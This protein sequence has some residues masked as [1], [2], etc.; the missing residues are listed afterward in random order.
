MYNLR[1]AEMNNLPD[2]HITTQTIYHLLIIR[3]RLTSSIHHGLKLWNS[4]MVNC[5]LC[6]WTAIRIYLL[7][8]T[9]P[10][11]YLKAMIFIFL[12]F[13]L[14]GLSKQL[15][16]SQNSVSKLSYPTPLLPVNNKRPF[17]QESVGFLL[18]IYRL[19]VKKEINAG[20]DIIPYITRERNDRNHF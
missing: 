2:Y 8:P 12:H 14:E 7:Q 5:S 11:D 4:I 15:C 10:A 9:W 13:Y 1:V 17:V 6:T 3:P 18:P 19:T 16:Y 20:A